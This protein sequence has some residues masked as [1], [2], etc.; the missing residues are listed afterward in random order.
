MEISL[1]EVEGVNGALVTYDMLGLGESQL[2]QREHIKLYEKVLKD[3]ESILN[4]M[5]KS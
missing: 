1:S 5:K 2:K 3:K 4:F